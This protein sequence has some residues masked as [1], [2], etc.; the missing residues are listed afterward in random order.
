[1]STCSFDNDRLCVL[2]VCAGNG[3]VGCAIKTITV[4]DSPYSTLDS[5]LIILVDASGGNITINLTENPDFKTQNYRFKRID[6]SSNTVTIVPEAGDTIDS[7][8]TYDLPRVTEVVELQKCV[9]ETNWEVTNDKVDRVLTTKGDI[10]VHNG[11]HL[12]RFP[13]GTDDQVLTADS[14]T[15]SGIKW[16]DNSATGGGNIAYSLLQNRVVAFKVAYT[17][18]SYFPW[19]QSRHGSYP[20]GTVVFRTTIG[21]RDLNIRLYNATTSTVL[22]SLTGINSTG[23][24]TFTITN[25]TADAQLELQVGTNSPGGIKAEVYGALLEFIA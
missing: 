20:A 14:A 23:T 7:G 18:I 11:T 24:Y 16:A 13:V 17:P 12:I 25:P 9:D 5:D 4:I 22:G 19:D 1:M 15:S 2:N 10:F 21:N 3:S 6:D 8:A